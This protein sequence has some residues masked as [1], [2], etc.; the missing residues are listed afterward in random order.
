MRIVKVTLYLLVMCIMLVPSGSAHLID[1]TVIEYSR[2]EFIYRIVVL[3]GIGLEAAEAHVSKIERVT[4]KGGHRSYYELIS[5]Y[6]YGYGYS[7]NAG[8]L[9]LISDYSTHRSISGIVGQWTAAPSSKYTW[10]E[11]YYLVDWT[12]SGIT[13]M[14]RGRVSISFD[15]DSRGARWLIKKLEEVGFDGVVFEGVWYAGK[16]QSWSA[17]RGLP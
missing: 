1:S 3:E 9:Y 8:V 13:Q 6:D 11:F 10:K 7:V 14:V 15:M 5:T 4:D 17:T 16:T 12:P 2:Q